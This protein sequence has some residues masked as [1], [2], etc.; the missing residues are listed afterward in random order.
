[1]RFPVVQ[2]RG[3]DRDTGQCHATGTT[4]SGA[5]ADPAAFLEPAQRTPGPPLEQVAAGQVDREPDAPDWDPFRRRELV[6]RLGKGGA[7][8]E[9]AALA[10]GEHLADDVGAWKSNGQLVAELDVLVVA[11]PGHRQ[12]GLRLPGDG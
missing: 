5:A 9:L 1:R 2:E 12:S 8:D 6:S 4:E 11:A 7:L 10:H 3:R